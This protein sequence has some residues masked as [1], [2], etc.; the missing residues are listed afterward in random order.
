MD[1]CGYGYGSMGESMGLCSYIIVNDKITVIG[2]SDLLH[3]DVSE[4]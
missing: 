4:Y 2:L 1:L 3:A